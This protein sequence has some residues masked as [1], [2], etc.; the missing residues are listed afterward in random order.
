MLTQA[1][2]KII[3]IRAIGIDKPSTDFLLIRYNADSTIDPTF[4]GNGIVKTDLNS[5]SDTV[6]PAALQADGKIVAVGNFNSQ[7]AVVRTLPDGTHDNF[8]GRQR[9]CF[10]HNQSGGN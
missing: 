3:V 7:F 10:N 5:K 8:W 9:T 1:D 2:G 6:L 4:E